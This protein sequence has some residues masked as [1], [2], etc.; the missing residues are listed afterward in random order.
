[1][2]FAGHSPKETP[3][4]IPPL[5]PEV[6]ESSQQQNP[7]KR[8]KTELI[9]DGDEDGETGIS[10]H[11]IMHEIRSGEA[12][13][14]KEANAIRDD[15]AT[16]REDVTSQIRN[17]QNSVELVTKKVEDLSTKV[18]EI[19][20]RVDDVAKMAWENKKMICLYK[21]DKLE[22]VME[23][24]GINEQV[25]KNEKDCKKIVMEVMKLHEIEISPSEIEHAYTK[26]INMKR[27]INGSNK[28]KLLTVV[29]TNLNAKIRIMKAKRDSKKDTNIY[30]NQALTYMNRNLIYKAKSIVGK[31][32]KVYF[33]RGCVR[34][35]KKDESEI[36]VDDES[37]LKDVQEYV[38]QIK[39]K[40]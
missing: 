25:F 28:K 37:K 35:Q 40:Q 34:V 36:M 19:D 39:S 7:L 32:L 20:G 24:D 8:K 13:R 11:D 4:K 26:E 27:K 12:A 18:T 33:A 17:M 14:K 16:M 3:P 1:M 6:T 30:F 22:K 5:I 9:I 2:L 31:Q 21:Q 10:L 23:I 38:D 29:F 15:I